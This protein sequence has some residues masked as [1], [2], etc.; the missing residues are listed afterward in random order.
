MQ[1][2]RL[3]ER[4]WNYIRFRPSFKR[5]NTWTV[6]CAGGRSYLASKLAHG[7]LICLVMLLNCHDFNLCKLS[8]QCTSLTFCEVA[9]NTRLG[10]LASIFDYVRFTKWSQPRPLG[11]KTRAVSHTKEGCDHQIKRSGT[12]NIRYGE[13]NRGCGYRG[14]PVMIVVYDQGREFRYQSDEMHSMLRVLSRFS[15]SKG[16]VE[17]LGSEVFAF[18]REVLQWV[19][20][21]KSAASRN[22]KNSI[23][24]RN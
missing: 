24:D 3:T 12:T 7:S 6:S 8:M 17:T 19:Q 10:T 20:R 15:G 16:F 23:Y 2:L 22:K 21:S 14:T 13:H 4:P 5:Y 9:Q 18:E 11:E 1:L